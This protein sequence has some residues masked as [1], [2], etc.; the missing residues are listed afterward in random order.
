VKLSALRAVAEAV[1]QVSIKRLRTWA[2]EEEKA[3]G[4]ISVF[5]AWLY[6][7][8]DALAALDAARSGGEEERE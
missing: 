7:V 2:E 8:I 3:R 5:S 4:Y 6:R 1:S